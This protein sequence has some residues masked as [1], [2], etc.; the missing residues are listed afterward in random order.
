MRGIAGKKTRYSCSQGERLCYLRSLRI[1]DTKEG[2][3]QPGLDQLPVLCCFVFGV[4]EERRRV[5]V[6]PSPLFRL[7]SEQFKTRR[8]LI[9]MFFSF[10]AV[11]F[12][13]PK[14]SSNM[15]SFSFCLWNFYRSFRLDVSNSFQLVTDCVFFVSFCCCSYRFPGLWAKGRCPPRRRVL[16][17]ACQPTMDWVQTDI[18]HQAIRL[19]HPVQPPLSETLPTAYEDA[20]FTNAISKAARKSTPKVP[21]S[22]RISER[23]QVSSCRLIT[24]CY[25]CVGSGRFKS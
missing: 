14:R 24:L 4:R 18:R 15:I 16:H 7:D 11:I 21:I 9:N 12:F 22:R 23:I 10:H 20:K 3:L 2:C 25:G 17:T 5:F 8:R 19:H 13:P 1:Q 6:K